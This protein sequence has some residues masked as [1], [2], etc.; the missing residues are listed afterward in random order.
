MGTITRF[1]LCPRGRVGNALITG[2][3]VAWERQHSNG[4]SGM[5]SLGDEDDF[6]ESFDGMDGISSSDYGGGVN[7]IPLLLHLNICN[8]R[9]HDSRANIITTN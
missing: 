5:D 9:H 3:R 2:A 4:S 6:D 1:H 8:C 7:Y